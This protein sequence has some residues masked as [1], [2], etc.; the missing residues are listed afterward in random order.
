MKKEEFNLK[1]RFNINR[2]CGQTSY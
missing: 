2:Q 1:L